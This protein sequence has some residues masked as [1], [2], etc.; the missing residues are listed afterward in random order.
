MVIPNKE[1]VNATSCNGQG[2]HGH[3]PDDQINT[4]IQIGSIIIV[5]FDLSLTNM[6]VMRTNNVFVKML[7]DETLM[8]MSIIIELIL[9][10]KLLGL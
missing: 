7:I 3:N 5:L 6:K 8:P 9:T 1:E 4:N 10:C 2:G